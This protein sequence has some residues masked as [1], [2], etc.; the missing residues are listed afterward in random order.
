VISVLS[1]R[2]PQSTRFLV[3]QKRGPRPLSLLVL[4]MAAVALGSCSQ[5]APA[6]AP[7]TTSVTRA[8]FA[9]HFTSGPEHGQDVI[10]ALTL[11]GGSGLLRF[12][13]TAE[14]RVVGDSL[15]SFTLYRG[16]QTLIQAKGVTRA[17][18]NVAGPFTEKQKDQVVGSGEWSALRIQN[19]TAAYAFLTDT[20]AR[21][22]S[23]SLL[24][25]G[26]NV[27]QLL[28]PDGTGWNLTWKRVG[29][30]TNGP[31][32]APLVITIQLPAHRSL[33]CIGN[34]LSHRSMQG[35]AGVFQDPE[36]RLQRICSAQ[37][38]SFPAASATQVP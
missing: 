5:P 15:F 22:Y 9:G 6:T 19:Y 7:S 11:E 8:L 12:A 35:F 34:V 17:A 29:G 25:L 36:S 4:L 28:L 2:A 16:H 26:N 30:P 24:L 38:L 37:L 3:P 18:G 20:T 23:G 32:P 27:G 10:G 14:W 13:N 33:V 1:L 31:S 21:D